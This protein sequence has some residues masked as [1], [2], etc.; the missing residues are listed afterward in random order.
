VHL[1]KGLLLHGPPGCGK[2][3]IAKTLASQAGL[4]FDA[5]STS[6]CKAMWL[7]H[8][9]DRLAKVFSEAR[10]KQPTLLFIDELDAVCP[11]RGAYAD[12]I[13]QE[14]TAQ[15]LQEVDGLLSDSLAIFLVGATNRSDQ[16]DGA[17]LSRFSEQIEMPLPDLTARTAL[18]EVFLGPLRFS[19]DRACAILNLAMATEGRSGRDLRALVN[20]AVLRAVKRTSSPKDFTLTEKDLALL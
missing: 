10:A 6:D 17:I 5:L 20:R 8:S 11:P 7:G 2:T 15:L 4:N 13:S 1:P 9:A 19:G 18:L 3:Q 12:A 14:F 16:V